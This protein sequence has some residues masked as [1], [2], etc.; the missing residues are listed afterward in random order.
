MAP[1]ARTTTQR[2]AQRRPGAA[3]PGNHE[4]AVGGDFR[5]QQI[6]NELRERVRQGLYQPGDKLPTERELS[7]QFQVAHLTIRRAHQ[8]LEAEG[9]I[10]RE[11]GRGTFVCELPPAPTEA[12]GHCTARIGYISIER[13]IEGRVFQ[14]IRAGLEQ[15]GRRLLLDV[16]DQTSVV[17]RLPELIEQERLELVLLDGRLDEAWLPSLTQLPTPVLVCGTIPPTPGVPS[18]TPDM[19]RWSYEL[20]KLLLQQLGFDQVWLVVEPLRLHYDRLVVSGYRQALRELDGPAELL[21]LCD[22][23]RWEPF[24]RQFNRLFPVLPGRHAVIWMYRYAFVPLSVLP[25]DTTDRLAVVNYGRRD[26]GWFLPAA[27]DLGELIPPD[28]Q[29]AQQIVELAEE[30]LAQTQPPGAGRVLLPD[31]ATG[32][33][34][35][36]PRVE[37]SWRV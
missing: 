37:L 29:Y 22:D 33:S 8:D 18:V 9:V 2:S 16:M 36:R 26:P 32:Q 25:T 13:Q 12:A 15:H 7:R 14:L 3:A 20:T 23:D 27:C 6:A 11:R 17:T 34:A 24:V 21:T 19:E 30:L 1:G 31:F 4:D 35:Q 5:Y 28:Q 10:R